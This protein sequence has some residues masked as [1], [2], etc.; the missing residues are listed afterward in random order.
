MNYCVSVK[1][2][3][4]GGNPNLLFAIVWGISLIGYCR[5]IINHLPILK[6][7]TD[8][9]EFLIVVIPIM[10][11]ISYFVKQ[12]NTFIALGLY[13]SFSLIYLLNFILFPENA[14][15]LSDNLF[16]TL[17]CALPFIFIGVNL[18]IEK[19]V[20][21]FYAL[22][23]VMVL[24]SGFY[25]LI[26]SGDVEEEEYNMDA[27]YM[28]LPHVLMCAMVLFRHFSIKRL[29]FVVLGILM[30]LSYGTR[31]P[32]ICFLVFSFV[33]YLTLS[34]NIN[35]WSL[36]LVTALG[37][38]ILK[39]LDEI[40]LFLA[41]FIGDVLGMSVRIFNKYLEGDVSNDSGRGFISNKLYNI[42]NNT[43]DNLGFGLWGSYKYVHTYPHNFI[44]DFWFSFGYAIG[45]LLLLGMSIMIYLS[46]RR[47]NHTQRCFLL[48]LFCCVIVKL[49][50]SGTFITD[51]L[52]YLY[53]GYMIRIIIQ[54]KQ[55][56]L[57]QSI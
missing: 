19:Y 33:H 46:F 42:L 2:Y 27:S 25:Y 53:M 6:W 44:L 32:V 40:M 10:L 54:N 36:V 57:S 39:F 12:K 55:G 45:S 23:V 4:F 3:L 22:S 5:G 28:L 24:M 26:Y 14:D 13:L 7:F 43:N 18:D 16:R 30:L 35:K 48:L 11:S 8:E 52:F 20:R 47:G 38:F 41:Y 37:G 49:M 21:P 34:L 15:I 31:G 56:V 9:I 51:S 29:L 1:K 17:C 50:L